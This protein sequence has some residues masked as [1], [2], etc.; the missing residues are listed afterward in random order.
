MIELKTG[1]KVVWKDGDIGLV[2]ENF[3]DG[4]DREDV[5]VFSPYGWSRFDELE[6]GSIKEVYQTMAY[7]TFTNGRLEINKD[8]KLIWELKKEKMIDVDGKEYSTETI[9]KALQEYVK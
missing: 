8:D 5:I 3:A 4:H 7:C 1:Y 2:M 6:E 9:K